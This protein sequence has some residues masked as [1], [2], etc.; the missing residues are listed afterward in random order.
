MTGSA[1]RKRLLA[2]RS[3]SA[4]RSPAMS[5]SVSAARASSIPSAPWVNSAS[6]QRSA[7]RSTA[8]FGGAEGDGVFRPPQS[9][10]PPQQPSLSSSCAARRP[11]RRARRRRKARPPVRPRS[12]SGTSAGSSAFRYAALPR[13]PRVVLRGGALDQP[14]DGRRRLGRAARDRRRRR[15][16][17]IAVGVVAL[18]ELARRGCAGPLRAA[19]RCSCAPPLAGLVLVEVHVDLSV[20]RRSSRACPGVSAVPHV[21]TASPTPHWMARATSRYPSIRIARPSWRMA[22]FAQDSP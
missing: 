1:R 17:E 12:R 22:S 3:S 10:S 21:A 13:G 7:G 11:A 8:G 2:A 4:D 14:L 6:S 15:L 20:K 16:L 9:L 5:A 18:R 19:R